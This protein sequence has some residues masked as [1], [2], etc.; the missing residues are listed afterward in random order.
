VVRHASLAR[1]IR[2]WLQ[3]RRGRLEVA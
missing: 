3:R 2:Q 1:L